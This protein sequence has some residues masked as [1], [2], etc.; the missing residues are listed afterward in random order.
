ML[1]MSH[2]VYLKLW[3]LGRPKLA[4]D[5]VLLYEAQD[6]NDVLARVLL[7]QE[8]AQRIAVGD[9][10]QQI[11]EWRGAKDALSTFE[12]E[13]GAEVRTLSQSFRFGQS[14]ADVA[15]A[16]LYH[17]GTP[18]RLTGWPAAESTVGPVDDPDAIRAAPMP[19][20]SAS[21]WSPLRPGRRPR[22]SAAAA[23]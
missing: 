13:L 11:Y 4:T 5:V 15:N 12:R 16:W 9:S 22:W 10:A 7:D 20:R 19:A 23:S 18:L 17:V 6:T 1:K 21:S 8:H 3:A 14:I 2:D